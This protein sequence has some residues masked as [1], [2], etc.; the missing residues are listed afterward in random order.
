MTKSKTSTVEELIVYGKSK[1]H[2]TQAKM[3]LA[4][5][6]NKNPLELLNCLNEEIPLEVRQKYQKQLELLNKKKPIQYVI[7]NT[8]FYGNKFLVNEHTL[9][10]RFETEELVEKTLYHIKKIFSDQTLKIIDLGTGT[11]CIGITLKKKL[12]NTEVTLVDIN[13]NTLEVTKQNVRNLQTE[14][15]IIQSDFWNQITQKYH[16]VISNPPYIKTTETIES[17]VK[18]NEPHIALYAGEDGL[19]CYRKIISNLKEH[20]LFPYI[21]AFEIGCTQKED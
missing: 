8:N 2:S 16:V 20:L 10:P 9:I 15:A 3:L 14:V 19:D 6:L 11:G 13:P 1:V 4:N 12:P 5:L 7:G 18:E 17:I 21:V